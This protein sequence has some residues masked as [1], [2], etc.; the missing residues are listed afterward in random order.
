MRK[1]IQATAA[2]IALSFAVNA[3]PALADE[4]KTHAEDGA[5]E[6]TLQSGVWT[7]ASF[8]SS[9]TW[10]IVERG[11][12][13]YVVLDEDFRTRRAPDLKI[14]LSPNEAGSITGDNATDGAV[15]VAELSSNRGAQAYKLPADVDLSQ[16]Q[17]IIIHC[18]AYS[19]LWSTASLS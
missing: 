14:F 8:R 16:Y 13:R 5:E 9:G 4:M 6:T 2:A 17:S 7:K 19:K 11:G 1:L 18:E 3:A 12:D 10:S 15:L